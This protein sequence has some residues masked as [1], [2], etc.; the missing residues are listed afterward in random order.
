MTTKPP[1]DPYADWTDE[2]KAEWQSAEKIRKRHADEVA[3]VL[4]DKLFG[5]AKGGG[6]VLPDGK[7]EPPPTTTPA[8]V[9][10]AKT[11]WFERKLWKSAPAD[12]AK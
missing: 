2:E 8:A 3:D 5:E 6:K 4:F 9:P 12:P 10:G 7:I 1:P 11:P